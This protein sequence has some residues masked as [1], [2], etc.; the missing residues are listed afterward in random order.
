MGVDKG[1]IAALITR[2][3]K[4]HVPIQQGVVILVGDG[5]VDGAKLGSSR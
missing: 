4:R 3:K 1:N 2:R 5:Y